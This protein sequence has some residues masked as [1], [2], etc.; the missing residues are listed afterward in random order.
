MVIAVTV[1]ATPGRTLLVFSEFKAQHHQYENDE[2][3]NKND[4]KWM[5][6]FDLKIAIYY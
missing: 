2:N 1:P 5:H 3:R 6:V 4:K